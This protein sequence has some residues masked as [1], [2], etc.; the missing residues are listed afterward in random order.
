MDILIITVS[1][2]SGLAGGAGGAFLGLKLFKP[3]VKKVILR[4]DTIELPEIV[5]E[6]LVFDPAKRRG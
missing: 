6:P 5:R 1:F 2:L 4:G 3:E